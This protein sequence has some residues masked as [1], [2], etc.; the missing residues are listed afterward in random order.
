MPYEPVWAEDDPRYRLSVLGDGAESVTTTGRLPPSDDGEH[1][2][3]DEDTVAMLVQPGAERSASVDVLQNVPAGV[4]VEK[5]FRGNAP[6][7]PTERIT[8]GFPRGTAQQV[9]A[10]CDGCAPSCS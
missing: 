4:I 7:R 6:A 3:V 5:R 10:G 2:R 1:S 8:A 9:S